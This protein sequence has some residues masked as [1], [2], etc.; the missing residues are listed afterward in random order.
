MKMEDWTNL[1]HGGRVYLDSLAVKLRGAGCSI[2]YSTSFVCALEV[3]MG[4][5]STFRRRC[6]TFPSFIVG[7]SER[8]VF[9]DTES[10]LASVPARAFWAENHCRALDTLL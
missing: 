5:F 7:A 1:S 10:K 3:E 8:R 2:L 9:C 6:H 4:P